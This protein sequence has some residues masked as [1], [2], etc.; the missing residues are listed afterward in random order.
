LLGCC[1]LQ[2]RFQLITN[3]CSVCGCLQAPFCGDCCTGVKLRTP[4]KPYL[5]RFS[6]R[7]LITLLPQQALHRMVF[8]SNVSQ[9]NSSQG[10]STGTSHK[11]ARPLAFARCC[12]FALQA[13]LHAAE[14]QTMIKLL[15]LQMHVRA[16]SVSGQLS[17]SPRWASAAAAWPCRRTVATK[18][19]PSWWQQTRRR[20]QVRAQLSCLL[21]LK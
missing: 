12:S 9:L 6:C 14:T 3:F 20:Q 13:W 11:P 19:P 7:V 16:C 10:S 8:S 1:Q 21:L 15:A 4:A 2:G 17:S 5:Q 18:W